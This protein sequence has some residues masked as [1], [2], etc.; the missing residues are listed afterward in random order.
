MKTIKLFQ[1]I[2]Y[3][4]VFFPNNQIKSISVYSEDLYNCNKLIKG[5]FPDKNIV[6]I[7]EI[8]NN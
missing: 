2:F 3:T 8:D 7:K 1:V 6:L 4:N 5:L